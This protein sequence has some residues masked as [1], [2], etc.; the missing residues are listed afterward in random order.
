MSKRG[1]LNDL[2][3]EVLRTLE[4]M[5]EKG[6]SQEVSRYHSRKIFFRRVEQFVVF[7]TPKLGANNS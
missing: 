4:I 1:K 5:V 6:L 7:Q 3:R 2:P